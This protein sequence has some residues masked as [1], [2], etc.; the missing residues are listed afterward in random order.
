M[1]IIITGTVIQN[2]LKE[3]HA[4]LTLT[5]QPGKTFFEWK[6]FNEHFNKAIE[7]GR[8]LKAKDPTCAKGMRRAE[9]LQELM[10][11]IYLARKKTEEVL[12]D[13]MLPGKTL[14]KF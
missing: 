1:R 6:S 10:R 8:S 13:F 3:L 14:N 12:G 4:I 9:E 2:N 7:Q 11:P 5:Y